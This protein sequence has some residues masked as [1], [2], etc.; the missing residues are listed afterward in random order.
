MRVTE[1]FDVAVIG[2][3]SAG[4]VAAAELVRAG[5][6]VALIEAGPDYGRSSE[7]WPRDLVDARRR[8]RRHDWGLEAELVRGQISDEPR[9]K[10]VAGCSA[11]NECAAV[12]PPGEDLDAWHLPG[13]SADEVR[14]FVDR[15]ESA[16]GGS[17]VRGRSGPLVTV[18][19]SDV[20]LT[21]WQARS[22][23]AALASGYAPL[24]DACAPGR[25]SGVAAFHAN[26]QGGRRINAAF[27]FLDPVR[28]DRHLVIFDRTEARQLVV[29]GEQVE[30]VRCVRGRRRLTIA[31]DRYVLCAGVYG[32]PLLLHR[33]GL[34]SRGLGRGLQDHPGVALTFRATRGA[35]R[36]LRTRN[37]FRSQVVL[38]ASSG[39]TQRGWD[40]H[41]LPY[42]AEGELA[43]LVFFMAPASRGVVHLQGR[44]PRIRFRFFE[45]GGK[46]D[47]AALE[48]EVGIAQQ[49]A[50]RIEDVIAT[51]DAPRVAGPS[52]RRWIESNVTGYDHAVGTCAMGRGRETVLDARCRVRGLRNVLVADASVIPR[53]PRANTNLLSMLIGMRAVSFAR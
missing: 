17:A 22:F 36:E 16:R 21:E 4:C 18:A 9:A 2:A 13:W 50:G 35:A 41:I 34:R 39:M 7:R 42:E 44:K 12:W 40:L 1:R 19:W 23:A 11:H 45:G 48:V 49:V 32:S 30:A 6:R 20:G 52:L 38:R 43:I 25:A 47:L 46:G 3:G 27:A 24:P 29:R 8:S 15:I 10:V 33:S 53:I 51:D 31:A 37:A 14:P 28:A 26:V 5:E